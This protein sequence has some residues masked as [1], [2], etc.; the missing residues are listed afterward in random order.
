MS[1]TVN[2]VLW[3]D[4]EAITLTDL[5]NMQQFVKAFLL[6]Q[7]VAQLGAYDGQD[8]LQPSTN[9]SKFALCPRPVAGYVKPTANAREI[10]NNPG[11]VYQWISVSTPT[12]LTSEL[13]AYQLAQDELKVAAAT[14]TSGNP[15]ID[16]LCV[17]LSTTAGPTVSRDFEDATTHVVSSQSMSVVTTVQMQFQLV[18]G[19]AASHPVSPSIPSGYCVYAYVLVPNS[20]GVLTYD[21]VWDARLP[22]RMGRKKVYASDFYYLTG[23]WQYRFGNEIDNGNSGSTL[24]SGNDYGLAK[25]GLTSDQ[26]LI[27]VSLAGNYASGTPSLEVL[28]ERINSVVGMITPSTPGATGLTSPGDIRLISV[29]SGG[30]GGG[31]TAP[32]ATGAFPSLFTG[33]GGCPHLWGNGWPSGVAVDFQGQQGIVCSDL[34]LK[35]VDTTGTSD[36]NGSIVTWLDVYYLF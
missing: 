36:G 1:S 18:Q 15:R 33:S 13:L 16:A 2:E 27:R 31:G 34:I 14:N 3:N 26:K 12:G 32:P 21:Q 25:L 9:M 28:A 29:T 22:M 35:L 6:D 8:G 23:C 11:M 7:G 5:E 10:T 4:G 24:G 20:A 30:F 17:K 19:T